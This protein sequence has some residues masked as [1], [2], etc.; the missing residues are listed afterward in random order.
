MASSGIRHSKSKWCLIPLILCFEASALTAQDTNSQVEPPPSIIQPV[1]EGNPL[2][3]G[4]FLRNE[5]QIWTSP[6]R[7]SSWKSPT[8]KKYG[9]PFLVVAAG[10]FASDQESVELLPNTPDQIKWS[11]R[12]SQLGASYTLAGFAGATYLVGKTIHNERASKTGL[13]GLEALA[14]TEVVVY[15]LKYMTARE[16]PNENDHEGR[17]WKGS[18]SFPSGHAATSFAVAT[19]F[20]YQYSNHIAV[21]IA[22]YSV[23]TAVAISRTSAR[24]HWPSDVVVGASIGFLIG[25]YVHKSHRYPAGSGPPAKTSRLIPAVEFGGGSG[26]LNWSF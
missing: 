26:T 1:D 25:R 16:R 6:F 20:A 18:D 9:I 19:V 24:R 8:M 2:D 23:A 17:L 15:G 4:R 14:H 7:P 10:L 22:A 13:M 12:V 21:P 5:Y 11:G 3:P